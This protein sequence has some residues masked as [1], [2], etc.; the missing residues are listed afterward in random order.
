MVGATN[1][2][3]GEFNEVEL[4]ALSIVSGKAIEN[5]SDIEVRT[6]IADG[7]RA[8]NDVQD[9]LD[10]TREASQQESAGSA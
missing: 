8:I 3:T 10:Y 9:L 1:R 2:E 6:R 4:P 5:L 7:V